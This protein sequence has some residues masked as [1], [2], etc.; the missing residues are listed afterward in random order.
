[1]KV[2]QLTREVFRMA[3]HCAEKIE[4]REVALFV[5]IRYKPSTLNTISHLIFSNRVCFHPMDKTKP[6]NPAST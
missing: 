5:R 1:M 4:A 3:N 6:G 2:D